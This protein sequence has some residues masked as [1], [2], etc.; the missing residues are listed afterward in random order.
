MAPAPFPRAAVPPGRCPGCAFPP[1]VCLC[2]EI[3]RL[4]TPWRFV[5]LRHASE[6]P[7]LTN[8]GRWAAAALEGAVLHDHARGEAPSDAPLGALLGAEP[9]ALLF[10]SAAPCDL[11]ALA[12]RTIVVPD[13]TWAQARRMVQ[14]LAPLR[15]LPRL[16]LAAPAPLARLRRPTV[17]GG[18]ST[19]EAIAGALERLGDPASAARLQELHAAAVERVLRL[20][21]MWPPDRNPHQAR[22]S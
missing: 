15:A 13:A 4:R 22:A 12:P 21:G 6:I 19:L 9:A 5:I 2:P 7:R 20:K 17:R 18:M 14:R 3:P 1:E 8:S 11:G 10:P 16:G